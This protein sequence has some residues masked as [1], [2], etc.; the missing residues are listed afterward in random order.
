MDRLLGSLG[1]DVVSLS[2]LHDDADDS[3]PFS[4]SPSSIYAIRLR[5]YFLIVQ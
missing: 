5:D 2:F 4:L 1:D 3:L